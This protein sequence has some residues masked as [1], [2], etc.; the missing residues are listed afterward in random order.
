MCACQES[1]IDCGVECVE[2]WGCQFRLWAV[3]LLRAAG[4][5]ALE[6]TA[7]DFRV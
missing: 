6:I 7:L 3:S 2:G 5:E 4:S 1:Q